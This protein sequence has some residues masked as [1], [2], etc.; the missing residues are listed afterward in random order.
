MLKR[1]NP[2]DAQILAG[3]FVKL[4]RKFLPSVFRKYLFC[5]HFFAR[6]FFYF[7]EYFHPKKPSWEIIKFI[8]GEDIAEM[9]QSLINANPCWSLPLQLPDYFSLAAVPPSID[10]VNA[11]TSN[12]RVRKAQVH[13]L[14][15]QR[16]VYFRLVNFVG[17]IDNSKGVPKELKQHSKR[18]RLLDAGIND[19]MRKKFIEPP[20]GHPT[21]LSS[22]GS[23]TE[24]L[25]N[26]TA[27]QALSKS[28]NK[29]LS[30]FIPYLLNYSIR[31]LLIFLNHFLLNV[32]QPKLNN[33]PE[34]I[35]IEDNVTTQTS[36]EAP[37][38]PFIYWS[39]YSNTK[40]GK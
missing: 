32:D 9:Y 24:F 23:L 40:N 26:Q 34:V 13:K 39:Y 12:R 35:T 29:Y 1:Q 6:I 38:K 18:K 4:L 14:K 31:N 33:S 3:L 10:S 37:W 11:D 19:L 36:N 17:D 25:A 21:T 8:L 7:S 30:G 28:K 5:S 2:Q 16:A 20:S 22:R 15:M 27:V